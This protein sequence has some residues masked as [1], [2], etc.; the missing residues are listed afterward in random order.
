MLESDL[1]TTPFTNDVHSIFNCRKRLRRREAPICCRC[2]RQSLPDELSASSLDLIAS[3][4]LP[5]L[6]SEKQCSSLV[7]QRL[8]LR[9]PYRQQ[10]ETMCI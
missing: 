3:F 7:G 1:L 6:L 10:L 8:A 5:S 9:L 4:Y 2:R